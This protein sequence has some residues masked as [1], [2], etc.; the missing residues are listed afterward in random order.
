MNL[1]DAIGIVKMKI[2][3][4]QS[5]DFD[6]KIEKTYRRAC[7]MFPAQMTVAHSVYANEL[8]KSLP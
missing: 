7:E 6:E 1:R 3:A 5:E 8:T 4:E 2:K